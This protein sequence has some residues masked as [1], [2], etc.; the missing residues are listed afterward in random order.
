MVSDNSSMAL[1]LLETGI[2]GKT[3]LGGE[4]FCFNGPPWDDFVA[5]KIGEP[6]SK[7]LFLTSPGIRYLLGDLK[8]KKPTIV[9]GSQPPE[10]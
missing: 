3:Q 10:T 4:A 2:L 6:L 7:S 1:G 9:S 5:A 8:K